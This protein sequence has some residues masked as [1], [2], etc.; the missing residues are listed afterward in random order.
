[1]YTITS[2]DTELDRSDIVQVHSADL[3]GINDKPGKSRVGI[4]HKQCAL[5]VHVLLVNS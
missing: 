1:M 2:S 3:K 4:P 5:H